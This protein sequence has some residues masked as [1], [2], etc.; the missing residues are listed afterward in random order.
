MAVKSAAAA[1]AALDSDAGRT[2]SVRN[3]VLYSE[4][5][6]VQSQQ[7]EEATFSA[8]AGQQSPSSSMRSLANASPPLLMIPNKAATSLMVESALQE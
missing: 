7:L 3:V 1:V 8:V 5:G 4:P 6:W 2:Q